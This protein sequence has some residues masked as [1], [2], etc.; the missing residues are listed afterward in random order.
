LTKYTVAVEGKQYTVDV[1][2]TDNKEQRFTVK[3]DDKPHEVELTKSK[4]EYETPFQL[5]IGEK[6]Y[7]VQISKIGKQAP[8]MVKIKDI[9]LKAEVKTQ[10]PHFTTQAAQ[11]PAPAIMTMKSPTGK[12]I[13]EGAITAPM[14]GKITSV[15]VKAGDS[16]KAGTVLCILEAMKMENEIVAPK[17]GTIQEVN[18]TE[19]STVNEGE[20][21]IILK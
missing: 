16:V 19:G 11:T 8:L 5:K 20:V 17:T 9:L 1:T 15:K 4:F 14:A 12:T 21:L 10:L 18:V 3:V 6:T 2:K 13:V 7:T